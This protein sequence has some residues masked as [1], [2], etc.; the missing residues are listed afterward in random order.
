MD[1]IVKAALA[2][3]PNVPACYGWLALDQRGQWRMRDAACQAA[4]LAGEVIR[5]PALLEF[6]ERNYQCD[7][8][9]CWYFQNGPQKVYVN[10]SS[11]PYILRLQRLDN[12]E[13]QARLHDGQSVPTPVRLAMT[14]TGQLLLGWDSAFAALDDRDLQHL[15]SALMSQNGVASDAEIVA[16]LDSE[17]AAQAL[18][19]RLA[20]HDYPLS[21]ATNSAWFK[22]YQFQASPLAHSDTPQ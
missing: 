4:G 5:H 12:G 11:A 7:Q 16:W 2:K 10:L 9:G 13:L 17:G 6:I 1:E 8:Q 21:Y 20:Q 3:W 14:Q 19:V 18:H 15:C 22:L